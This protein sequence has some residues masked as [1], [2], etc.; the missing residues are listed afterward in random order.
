MAWQPSLSSRKHGADASAPV[1]GAFVLSLPSGW[2]LG[3]DMASICH[4]LSRPFVT[5][6]CHARRRDA[7]DASHHQGDPGGIPPVP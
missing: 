2:Q 4:A 5:P 3:L 7:K 1:P 6:I